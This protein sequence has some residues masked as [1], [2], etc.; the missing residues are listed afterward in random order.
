[1]K[2]ASSN[3][4][5][6][7]N[8]DLAGHSDYHIHQ[9]M[10]YKFTDGTEIRNSEDTYF[11]GTNILYN[12]YD[13]SSAD[14]MYHGNLT[15][16]ADMTATILAPCANVTANAV[17]GSV[18]AQNIVTYGGETHN[19][20][21]TVVS[22]PGIKVVPVPETLVKVV[23]KKVSTDGKAL[24]GAVFQVRDMEGKLVSFKTSSRGDYT[25]AVS[26]AAEGTTIWIKPGNYYLVEIG[27]PAGYILNSE[28]IP[29]QVTDKGAVNGTFNTQVI[30]ERQID[31]VIAPL[32]TAGGGFKVVAGGAYAQLPTERFGSVIMN[33]I[34]VTATFSTQIPAGVQLGV[35]IVD[36]LPKYLHAPE[37]PANS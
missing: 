2:R 18:I 4:S 19:S 10:T 1:M 30:N 26:V 22:I 8:L 25:T 5:L 31:K 7:I 35:E 13:S 27:A 36:A 20:R 9:A 33:A 15:N 29:F 12:I 34:D 3:Q 17:N 28:R 23:L 21:F 6:I 16:D 14:G 11:S 24:S 37:S 32:T